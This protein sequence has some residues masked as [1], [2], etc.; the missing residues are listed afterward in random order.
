[1]GWPRSMAS[2]IRVTSLMRAD[3][4]EG[5]PGGISKESTDESSY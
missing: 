1:L 5:T 4:A 3:Y 2:R